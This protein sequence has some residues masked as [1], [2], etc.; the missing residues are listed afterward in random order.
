MKITSAADIT[1]DY[2]TYLIYANPGVG[3]TKSL[4]YLPGR[5][6]L[7]DI[8]HS[9]IVLQGNENID[10]VRV[11]SHN[12]WNEW[13][14]VVADLIENKE[15]YEE[16]YTNIAIDNVSELFKSTLA[17]LGR[18]GKNNRVPSM[19]AYQRV[20]FVILDSLR[21]LNKLNVRLVLT[22]WETSDK[23]ETESGQAFNRAMPDIR[24]KIINNF[25][26]LTDVVARLS[27]RKDNDGNI[28]RGFVLQP[29]DSVYAK[30][31]LDDREGCLVDEL[32]Q[33]AEEDEV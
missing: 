5:T 23:W 12:I 15:K 7:I 17:N 13:L 1:A 20:D 18:E 30:N 14:G 8:D 2:S 6:L 32:V 11:D 33:E 9:S 29:T 3:K 19:D 16:T 4:E 28:I 22:A 24:P 21:A 10:I 25:M 27:A 26:G 31:R